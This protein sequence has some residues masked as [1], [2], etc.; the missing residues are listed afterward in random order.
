MFTE[1]SPEVLRAW[2]RFIWLSVVALCCIAAKLIA[3][4]IGNSRLSWLI[5]RLFVALGL[6][7]V[8]LVGGAT[9]D[10]LFRFKV[11]FITS[12]VNIG[13]W[14]YILY[15]LLRFFFRLR[16]DNAEFHRTDGGATPNPF[17][18]NKPRVRDLLDEMFDELKINMR[19][20]DKLKKEMSKHL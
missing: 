7:L 3:R 10:S 12:G 1:Y 18:I 2:I 13:F 16:N 20:T 19:K 8:G 4:E 9:L 5:N 15:L 14:S 11:A 6:F 17:Y